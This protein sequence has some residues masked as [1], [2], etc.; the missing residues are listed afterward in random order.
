M[1]IE[2]LEHGQ[3]QSVSPL[4]G[5]YLSKLRFPRCMCAAD[6]STDSSSILVPSTSLASSAVSFIPSSITFSTMKFFTASSVA[7]I[8]AFTPSLV[9][10]ANITA[11]IGVSKDGQ[12]GLV[13][14]LVA[15][16]QLCLTHYNLP[17]RRFTLCSSLHQVATS[18]IS[19]FAMDTIYGLFNLRGKQF[20]SHP[21]D[22][23]TVTRVA[24]PTHAHVSRLLFVVDLP[25]WPLRL[26]LGSFNTSTTHDGFNSGFI[27]F[28]PLSRRVGV[29]SLEITDPNTPAW[30]SVGRTSRI[31]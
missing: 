4:L 2:R 27:P 18:S 23:Q 19:S 15:K 14:F 11:L 24:S 8:T 21:P 30:L 26:L 20:I 29:Y 28:N 3:S 5:F 13:G 17:L 1:R 7:I 9:Y 22:V 25:I 10:G 31:T 6:N 12:A 16:T